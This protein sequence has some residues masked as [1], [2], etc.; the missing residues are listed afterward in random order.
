MSDDNPGFFVDPS[1]AIDFGPSVVDELR[2]LLAQALCPY[3]SCV[4]GIT[5]HADGTRSPCAWCER[6]KKSIESPVPGEGKC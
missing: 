5:F 6:R 3:I 4:N 2:T 1:G